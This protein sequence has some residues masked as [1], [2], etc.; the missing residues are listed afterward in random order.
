[1]SFAIFPP[2]INSGL[3]YTGPGSGS[4]LSAA[5]AWNSLASDLTSAATSSQSVIANLTTGPWTGPSATVMAS[6]AGPYV[7]WLHA[8]AASAEQAGTQA[9]AVAGA[10]ETARASSVPP[11][12]IAANRAQLAS[13]VATNWLGQNTPAIAANEAHYMSMW[14]QDALAMD[15]YAASAQTATT[16]LPA[17][18]AAP[19]VATGLPSTAGVVQS[20]ATNASAL[21]TQAAPAAASDPLSSLFS[22]LG[23]AA[24]S[25]GSAAGAGGTSSLAGLQLIYYPALIATLPLRVLLGLIIQL[26]TAA[27][28]GAGLAGATGAAGSGT[29]AG[30]QLLTNVGNLVDGKLKLISG[31][32]ANQLRAFGSAISAK[33]ASA[34]SMGG[35]SVPQSW[36][37]GTAM[38]RAVPE[39]PATTVSPLTPAPSAGMPG[40]PYGQAMLGAL[41]GR[42]LSTLAGKVPG[43]KVVPKSPAGG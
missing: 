22:G 16:A 24:G 19:Q 35:L 33:L 10:Y 20:A 6:A 23:S 5:S 4:L 9:T 25:T 31:G 42:G 40:G 18:A 43:P 7:G 36:S 14:S 37:T 41:S 30:E 26:V 15:T 39:L 28:R 21:A 12:V 38:G 32:V 27:S 11:P 1:M 34:H 13:L 29:L 8:T 17:Q 2:E 3:I